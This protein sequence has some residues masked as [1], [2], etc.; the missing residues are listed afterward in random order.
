[1]YPDVLK[2]RN[3]ENTFVYKLVFKHVFQLKF[4]NVIEL[5]YC[6]Y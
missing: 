1:M 4:L 3:S 6:E 5:D 2:I